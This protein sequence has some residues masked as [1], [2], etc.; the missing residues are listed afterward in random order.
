MSFSGDLYRHSSVPGQHAH[1]RGSAHSCHRQCRTDSQFISRFFRLR[2]KVYRKVRS[3]R[4]GFRKSS[5]REP[6]PRSLSSPHSPRQQSRRSWGAVPGKVIFAFQGALT[7]LT[8]LREASRGE[9]QVG[10][11]KSR[12]RPRQ[13]AGA[14]GSAQRAQPPRAQARVTH[15]TWRSRR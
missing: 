9:S 12:A 5:G 14:A 1:S 10:E 3:E 7:R 11:G 15:G 13:G 6:C 8:S 4:K 2:D